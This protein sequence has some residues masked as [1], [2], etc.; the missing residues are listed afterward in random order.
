V[1]QAR[2]ERSPARRHPLSEW[3]EV[4]IHSR[5]AARRVFGGQRAEITKWNPGV[6]STTNVVAVRT[7][8]QDAAVRSG[9]DTRDRG[10]IYMREKPRG[11]RTSEK[12]KYEIVRGNLETLSFAGRLSVYRRYIGAYREVVHWRIREPVFVPTCFRLR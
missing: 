6:Q 1:L 2:E 4:Q 12:A 5:E 10:R 11:M 8:V 7:D 9:T 3:C